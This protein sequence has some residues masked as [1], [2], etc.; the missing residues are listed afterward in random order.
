M[1]WRL[2][3]VVVAAIVL[4]SL[5][6]FRAR[7]P[8]RSDAVSAVVPAVHR[9]P[10]Q[11]AAAQYPAAPP[12]SAPPSVLPQVRELFARAAQLS[13]GELEAE[14]DLRSALTALLT[15]ENV[16]DIFSGLSE[17]ERAS[18]FGVAVFGRWASADPIGAAQWLAQQPS[19]RFE[20]T[21]ALANANVGDPA[22]IDAIERELPL[23]GARDDFLAAASR[24]V[25]GKDL[26]RAADLAGRISPGV[27]RSTALFALADTW[28]QRDPV[29][30]A[31]WIASQPDPTLRDEL[32]RVAAVAET[33]G[34]P[35]AAL[36]WALRAPASPEG[37]DR[38]LEAVY[39]HWSSF[40]PD[41][42]QRFAALVSAS[43]TGGRARP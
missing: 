35:I 7:A 19:P 28:I 9:S 39:G 29:S 34:D 16:A 41:A 33:S 31:A 12:L 43:E 24:L 23:G 32:V 37:C 3:G 21:Y 8:A 14:D 22:Q 4:L 25:T 5:A 27:T 13:P 6:A 1:S 15:D 11:R 40:A 20:Q 42:A 18:E 36:E 26:A 17:E 2:P 38:A 10:L 30:A